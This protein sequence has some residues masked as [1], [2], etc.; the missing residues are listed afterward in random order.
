MK[1]FITFFA[2]A[3]LA[4]VGCKKE[5]ATGVLGGDQTVTFSVVADNAATKAGEVT[6]IPT[7]INKC[8]A[9]VRMYDADNQLLNDI[10]AQPACTKDGNSYK[11]SVDL[12]GGQKY[13]V[14]VLMYTDGVYTVDSTLESIERVDKTARNAANLDVFSASVT[15]SAGDATPLIIAKR[16]FAQLNLITTD[17]VEHFEPAIKLKYTAPKT[18]NAVTGEVSGE[19]VVYE[20]VGTYTYAYAPSQCSISSDYI[21]ASDEKSLLSVEMTATKTGDFVRTF[22]NLPLQRNYKTNVIGK[23]LSVNAPFTVQVNA[24]WYTPDTD[25][26]WKSAENIEAANAILAAAT[27]GQDVN[28]SVNVPDDAA[29]VPVE[30]TPAN[31]GSDIALTFGDHSEGTPLTITFTKDEDATVNPASVTVEA[32]A[33]TTLVFET[34]T[35]VVINGTNYGV[36]S[37]TFSANTLVINNGVSVEKVIMTAG[38]LEVHGSLGAFEAAASHGEIIVRDCEGLSAEVK[39]ALIPFLAPNYKAVANGSKFDIVQKIVAEVNGTEYTNLQ[40]AINNAPSGS[41]LVISDDFIADPVIIPAGKELTIDL[42]GK[43][44]AVNGNNQGVWATVNGKLSL[45]GAGYL[46]DATHNKVGFLF[47]LV[48]EMNVDATATFESGLEC[49]ETRSAAAKLY[50]HAGHWIGDV[51]DGR[52]WTFNKLDKVKEAL[53]EV[54]GGTFYK[55]NPAEAQTEYPYENWVKEGYQSVYDE[56]TQIYSV[57]EIP[58]VA[59]IGTVKYATLA[60]AFAAVEAGETIEILKAGEYKVPGISKNI[61]VKGGVEGVVFNCVGSGSIASIPNG[62]TFEGVTLNMGQTEYHGFHHGGY[63]QYK[64]CVINGYYK[65]YGKTR[66][67]GCTFNQDTYSYCLNAYGTDLDVID[68][69]FNNLGKAFY[70][71]NEGA[72]YYTVNFSGCTFNVTYGTKAKPQIFV[73]NNVANQ[74]Y[75]VNITGCQIGTSNKTIDEYRSL[76]IDPDLT[77]GKGDFRL[78]NI[79]EGGSKGKYVVVTLDGETVYSYGSLE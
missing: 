74:K 76:D 1:K 54:D 43:T 66:F 11:F 59:K 36:I 42:N 23:L 79:E 27:A 62:C 24:D 5:I 25:I 19:Q 75:T 8:V 44:I 9:V 58:A 33:G 12:M 64:N 18:F 78:W 40:D 69:V 37:G 61:T 49:V 21:F 55:F 73:K 48:G 29:T 17:L 7:T 32:P 6:A 72:G 4:L 41:E 77:N 30:F 60:E 28:I 56:A 38:G 53:I 31:S 46:G 14:T 70:C 2:L 45:E 67:E 63:I 35:H 57:V 68:C 15:Y 47:F 16:P 52:V 50:V 13:E 71:Y 34:E 22:D 39:D 20:T 51:Y 3:A 26:Q 65:T 10:Y